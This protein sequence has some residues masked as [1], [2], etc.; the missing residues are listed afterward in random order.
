M[1]KKEE[2]LV[3]ATNVRKVIQQMRGVQEET[4]EQL[5]SDLEAAYQHNVEKCGDMAPVVKSECDQSLE[6]AQKRLVQLKEQKAASKVRQVIQ[7]MRF[8]LP[9][10]YEEVKVELETV[11]AAELENCGSAAE[12]VKAESEKCVEMGA[13]RVEQVKEQ[14]IK[15][16]ERRVQLEKERKEAQAKAELLLEELN[17][18]V[19]EAET[20][21]AAME[22]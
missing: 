15:E 14:R 7:K 18:F 8:V 5:K 22:E 2:E 16:E 19:E 21:I 12:Q 3:A 17:G 9:E 13:E 6:Q 4:Y 11:M 20:A 1:K 10:T